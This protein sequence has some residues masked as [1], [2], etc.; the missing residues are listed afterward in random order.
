V[1]FQK[2]SNAANTSVGIELPIHRRRDLLAVLV[3]SVAEVQPTVG[4]SFVEAQRRQEG[5][6]P[7]IS[8]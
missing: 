3:V 4:S 2:K 1:R 7:A 5:V 8:F 6:E